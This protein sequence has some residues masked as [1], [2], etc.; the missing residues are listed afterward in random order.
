[1][2]CFDYSILSFLNEFSRKYIIFDLFMNI[3]QANHLIKGGVFMILIWWFWFQNKKP[4]HYIRERIVLTISSGF[5][6]LLT[7]RVLAWALPFRIRPLNNADISFL[8][9][10]GS[11]YALLETW[12]SFPSDHAILFFALAT[13]IF[14]ISRKAGIA[15]M[16]YTLVVIC[17]PRLYLGL[18]YP[19]DILAG[20]VAGAGITL[21]VSLNQV[22]RYILPPVTSWQN[23]DP[24]SFY[25]FFF[26][27]S[28]MISTMF[29]PVRSLGR[30]LYRMYI[31]F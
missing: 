6:A 21:V 13:G 8:C 16:I 11:N 24:G 31:S 26:F 25:A 20:A 27:L 19:T 23:K 12:S 3:L 14:L 15:L 22:S 18:H 9:P 4:D 29:D 17:F 30:F 2:N 10:Y 1:M 7:S 5:I 28:F